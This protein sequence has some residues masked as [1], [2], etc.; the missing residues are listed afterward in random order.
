MTYL[1]FFTPTYL[2]AFENNED[3]ATNPVEMLSVEVVLE[4]GEG[5]VWEAEAVPDD[6]ER[7]ILWF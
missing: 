4:L 5:L 7:E 1:D 2:Q 3:T 6:W